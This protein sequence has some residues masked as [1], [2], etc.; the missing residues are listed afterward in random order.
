MSG[1]IGSA[2]LQPIGRDGRRDLQ[3]APT[4]HDD[5]ETGE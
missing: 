5:R 1:S 2:K 3:H 4:D